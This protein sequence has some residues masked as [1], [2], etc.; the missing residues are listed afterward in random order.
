MDCHARIGSVRPFRGNSRAL[1]EEHRQIFRDDVRSSAV[2]WVS[3]SRRLGDADIEVGR[4]ADEESGLLKVGKRSVSSNV[5]RSGAIGK[6]S[7]FFQSFKPRSTQS[8]KAIIALRWAICLSLLLMICEI[9]AGVIANSLPVIVDAAHFLSDVGGF[10]VS[11]LSIHLRSKVATSDATYGYQ[12]AEIL[13]AL[14]SVAIIWSMTGMLFGKAVQRL[15]TPQS[16]DGKRMTLIAGMGL[17][18]N[19]AL[20]R[21]LGNGGHGQ[22]HGNGQGRG[23]DH[24][25]SHGHSHGHGHGRSGCHKLG[26]VEAESLA[27]KA[28]FVHVLGDMVQ[29]VGVMIAGLLIWY[30]PFDVGLTEDGVSKWCYCDPI[31]TF[32]FSILVMITTV[33]TVKQ[34]VRQIMMATPLGLDVQEMYRSILKIPNVVTAHDLHVWQ[35]GSSK[36]ITAHVVIDRCCNGRALPAANGQWTCCQLHYRRS[37][38]AVL[39]ECIKLAD[40]EHGIQHSTFQLEVQDLFDHSIERL[41]LGDGSC[42]EVTCEPDGNCAIAKLPGSGPVWTQ[43]SRN[44]AVPCLPHI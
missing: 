39:E 24:G 3:P 44:Q 42:H 35:V 13:G 12:Q 36:M 38:T 31:C 7:S 2:S 6:I 28:A 19:F 32:I 37:G 29:S 22:G 1:A 15:I 18:I 40:R 21:V 11:A 34:A 41:Q 23:H 17:V 10:I 14:I 43:R 33:G 8:K 25:H 5:R 26:K 27:M 16:I 20:M 4:V 30:Q 9:V